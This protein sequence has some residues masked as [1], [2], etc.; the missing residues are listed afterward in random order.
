MKK[1]LPQILLAA[2][3]VMLLSMTI[4]VG[5]G[6]ST[7]DNLTGTRWDL[8]AVTVNG[9]ETDAQTWKSQQGYPEG[10]T[11]AFEFTE[12]QATMVLINERL[13]HP[14]YYETGWGNIN[15]EEMPFT[16]DGSTMWVTIGDGQMT[17][18]RTDNVEG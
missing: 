7:P 6:E 10:S 17:F 8:S 4:L 11:I 13:S 1:R 9:Q 16:I 18:Q 3:A 2:F 12:D 5:C 15:N 14:Y